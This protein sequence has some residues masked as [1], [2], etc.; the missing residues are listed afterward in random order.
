MTNWVSNIELITVSHESIVEQMSVHLFYI[1]LAM[2][3]AIED[4]N[5]LEALSALDL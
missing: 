5:I 4:M 3:A 2:V 1:R